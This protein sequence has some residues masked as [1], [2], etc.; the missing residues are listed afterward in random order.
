MRMRALWW[1]AAAS[2][3]AGDSV[4]RQ[5]LIEGRYRVVGEVRRPIRLTKRRGTQTALVLVISSALLLGLYEVVNPLSEK[6]TDWLFSPRSC[7]TRCGS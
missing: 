2:A 6:L 4:R 3:A 7:V 1:G 5:R